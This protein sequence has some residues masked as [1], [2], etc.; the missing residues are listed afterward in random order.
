MVETRV[1]RLREWARAH[2]AL[3]LG[4]G[5]TLA[6]QIAIGFLPLFGGPGYEHAFAT[7]LLLPATVLISVALD[8]ARAGAHLAPRHVAFGVAWGMLHAALAL[9]VAFLHLLHVRACAPFSQV[10]YFLLTA[11]MGALLAG[12]W[13]PMLA[14]LVRRTARKRLAAVTLGIALPLGSAAVSLWRFYRSPMIFAYDP[15]V[16]FF[17]G[18][19]YDTIVAPGVALVTYRAGTILTLGALVAYAYTHVASQRLVARFCLFVLAGASLAHTGYATKFG[20]AS[21]ST[22]IADALGGRMEGTR[23]VVV[24]P[25][26]LRKAEAKLLLRDCEGQLFDVEAALGVRAPN[27]VTAYFFRDAEEKKRLMGAAHVYI[28]KPWRNEVYLQLGGFPHPVLGHELAHVVAGA[29]GRGPFRIGG[30]FGGY[31]PDPGLIEGVAT[32]ASPDEEDMTDAQWARAMKELGILPPLRR[33][34]SIGFLGENSATSYTVAGAFVDWLIQ[35]HGRQALHRWYGGQSLDTVL[36][37][38]WSTIEAEFLA[39]LNTVVLPPQALAFA[40]AKFKRP[41]V[42]ARACPHLVDETRGLA[43]QSRDACDL[44][45][46]KRLYDAVLARDPH[47]YASQI[48]RAQADARCGD[49][50]AGIYALQSAIQQMPRAQRDKAREAIADALLL[51]GDPTA[52]A[53]YETLARDTLDEDLG[54]SYDV[55][56]YAA[57]HPEVQGAVVS[58]L[59]GSPGGAPPDLLHAGYQLGKASDHPLV[60]YLVAKNLAQHGHYREASEVLRDLPTV[61]LPIRVQRELLRQELIVACANRDEGQIHSLS[62]RSIER[63]F[64]GSFGGKRAGYERLLQRCLRGY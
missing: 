6:T 19:L 32:A 50:E 1:Q 7:G 56:A 39:S 4:L 58:L 16:G 64:L 51:R 47:D 21:T 18:T 57:T 22:S 14:L 52:A 5:F 34:F 45:N 59:I 48:S 38:P 15:F 41:G 2:S 46:A 55:K 33:I 9:G 28:A 11:A 31:W 25:R 17:S 44:E 36:A 13:A 37:L 60:R 3:A 49:T 53:M 61:D 63:T 29:V 54:R 35:A 24:Y 12:A 23:C 26:T 20:H 30:R 10:P 40:E 42:F 62:E 8:E 43:D 27:V